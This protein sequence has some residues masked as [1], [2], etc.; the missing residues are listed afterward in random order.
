[1]PILDAAL[2]F[3]LTM[4]VVATVVTQIVRFMRNTAKL[5]NDELHK[6]LTEY[7]SK[8]LKPVVQREVNKLKKNI[9]DDVAEELV[10]TADK[11]N[12][13]ELFE[14]EELTKL[15]EV[16]TDKLTERL[17]ES[18]FGQTLLTK[19]GDQA[20]ATFDKLGRRYEVVGD[21]F[22][23]TFRKKSRLWATCVALVLA[24]VF[25][26]DSIHILNSYIRNEGMR[27]IVIA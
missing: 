26:I 25:N 6:M 9:S 22:T 11:L 7:F 4:L 20:Q 24:L 12:T 18:E 27:Q 19:L 23:D 1:M 16:S 14:K 8:E 15:I 21:K 3:A 10:K 17:K 5:R 2:A 13:S